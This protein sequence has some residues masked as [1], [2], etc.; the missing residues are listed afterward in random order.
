MDAF[1][2]GRQ[3]GNPVPIIMM[4]SVAETCGSMIGHRFPPSRLYTIDIPSGTLVHIHP[5]RLPSSIIIAGVILLPALTPG[6][7]TTRRLTHIPVACSIPDSL[8]IP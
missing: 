8:N 7:G 1:V 5:A 2:S 3:T 4:A 6:I